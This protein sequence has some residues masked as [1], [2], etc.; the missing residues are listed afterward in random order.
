[1]V[2]RTA[3]IDDLICWI[4]LEGKSVVA[5]VVRPHESWLEIVGTAVAPRPLSEEFDSQGEDKYR[6]DQILELGMDVETIYML[7]I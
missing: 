1:M 5:V 4:P 3:R 2:A 7:L 6:R